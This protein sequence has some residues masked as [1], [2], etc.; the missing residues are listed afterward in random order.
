MGFGNKPS[1]ADIGSLL[2]VGGLFPALSSILQIPDTSQ[3]PLQADGFTKT[4]DWDITEP[5]RT[6]LDLGIV[7]L[8]LSYQA[9]GTKAHA[10]IVLDATPGAPKWSITITNVSVEAV[11][12]G[13]GSD[14]LLSI[15]G[16]FQA[17]SIDQTRLCR[18]SGRHP[19]GYPARSA[20]STATP[21]QRSRTSSPD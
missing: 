20:C 4:Y 21:C 13:F 15:Q 8:V 14:P 7:H 17:G 12:D 10:T 16:G 9:N 1:L 11:V 3:L 18:P 5:D 6:L 2:G 19:A